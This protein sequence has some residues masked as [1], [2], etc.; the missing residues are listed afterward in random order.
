MNPQLQSVYQILVHGQNANSYKFALLRALVDIRRASGTDIEVVSREALAER[1][2]EYYW[3]LATLYR[4]RQSID[5]AKGPV[6]MR[7]IDALVNRG[8][9]RPRQKVADFSRRHAQEYR[10]LVQTV[11]KTAFG[12]VIPRFHNVRGQAVN[13][14]LFAET[15]EGL[16][17][18]KGASLF[19]AEHADLLRFMAIAAWVKFTEDYTAS[20]RLFAK[21]ADQPPARR[22]VKYRVA[23]RSVE[24]HGCF[25][26][27]GASE[28]FAVDHVIPW[29]YVLEDKAWNLVLA[30]TSCNSAKSD[31]LPE[32]LM[33][34]R[35]KQ[36]NVAWS[37]RAGSLPD[38]IGRDLREWESAER[39]NE[40]LQ[41]TW[42][43]ARQDGFPVWGGAR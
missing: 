11:A 25:Y 3:P 29:S 12:D 2:V 34:E 10:A 36:R 42:E 40:H 9:T 13:P 38:R 35:L 1:F 32:E 39:V 7:Y 27:R 19:L 6:V 5:P 33:L 31:G 15:R 18:A 21:I 28:Q 30:C 17:L 43:Q 41:T 26:C 37:A 22:T 23:L 24:E 20:P 14:R 4:V 16:A 8:V